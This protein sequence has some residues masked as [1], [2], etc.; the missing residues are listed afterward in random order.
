MLCVTE[1]LVISTDMTT[2]LIRLCLRPLI[3]L[4][5][6][7]WRQFSVRFSSSLLS[8]FVNDSSSSVI[9][10]LT[11]DERSP[12]SVLRGLHSPLLHRLISNLLS[13]SMWLHPYGTT[14][15]HCI[16]YRKQQPFTYRRYLASA[17]CIRL[18]S[19]LSSYRFRRTFVF[20]NFRLVYGIRPPSCLLFYR[21]LC[22]WFLLNRTYKKWFYVFILRDVLFTCEEV[23]LKE[24]IWKTF[25]NR[26]ILLCYLNVV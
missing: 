6:T 25:V 19:S 7:T 11:Y 21:F 20:T 5:S 14:F 23:K 15:V 24:E 26:L 8:M 18:G 3:T 16:E 12:V 4:I 1:T 9:V 22:R 17:A 2:L 13:K 10:S